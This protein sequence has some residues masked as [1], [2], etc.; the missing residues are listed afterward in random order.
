MTRILS[1]KLLL[2]LALL[3]IVGMVVWA[4]RKPSISTNEAD[5]S[6]AVEASVAAQR[7]ADQERHTPSKDDA[8]SAAIDAAK[9]A[10][11][12]DENHD[13]RDVEVIKQ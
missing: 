7:I 13:K 1:G 12:R 2:V 10:A 8:A 11:S 3:V 5:V 4:V 9:A 6:R